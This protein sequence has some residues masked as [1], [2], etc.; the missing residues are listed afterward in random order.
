V[1]RIQRITPAHPLYPQ[2]VE[3]REA[4]LLRPIG[5][6]LA[7]FSAAYPV[8]DKAEHF[9]AIFDHPTGPKV[10]GCALLLPPGVIPGPAGGASGQAA[11]SSG[12]APTGEGPRRAKL[13]QMAVH[14]QRQGEGIGRRLVIAVE[15]RALGELGVDELF[16]HAQD[17]AIGF[18]ES[19]GWESEGDWFVEAGIQHKRM[20]ARPVPTIAPFETAEIEE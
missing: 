5:Y 1:I 3:L 4:V 8:E 16:C 11:G 15:A 2:E 14:P 6:D 9:V 13:M 12:G 20:V 10:V 18:Y 17:R 7:K 19:L